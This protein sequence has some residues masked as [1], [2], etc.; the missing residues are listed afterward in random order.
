[1]APTTAT[2][3]PASQTNPAPMFAPMMHGEPSGIRE[4]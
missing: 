1:M 3:I 2:A 4:A